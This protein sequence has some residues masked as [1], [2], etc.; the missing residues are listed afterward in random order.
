MKKTILIIA[1]FIAGIIAFEACNNNT[2]NKT[3]GKDTAQ[4]TIANQNESNNTT[5][6]KMSSDIMAAMNNSMMKM[7]DLKQTGDFD[8]DFANMMIAHHEGAI[9][10]SQIEVSK[11]SNAQVKGWAQ[12][13]I[14]AQK[15]EIAQLQDFVKNYKTPEEK[16]ENVNAHN[17]L[18]EINEKMQED[19]KQ[20]QMTGNMDKDFVTMMIMHHQA[21]VDMAKDELSHGK[22]ADLKKMAQKIIQ[23]QI[24]EVND[25]QGWLGSHK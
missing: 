25:F 23:D 15:N 18:H 21:A 16:K 6:D 7:E 24:K 13:I 10:A 20:M 8:Y 22:N 19:M 1:S 2:E 3:T 12:K 14:D 17:E 11:G 9:A 5:T 4:T